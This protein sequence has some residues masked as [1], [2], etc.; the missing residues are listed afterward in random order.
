MKKIGILIFVITLLTIY[1][2]PM[3]AAAAQPTS[4]KEEVI[5]G[6]LNSDGSVNNIYV[7]NIF[8]GGTIDD[9]GNYSEVSNMTSTEPMNK[10]EDHITLNTTADKFYYQGTLNSK[11]LPWNIVIR[12]FLNGSELSA[13]ELAGKSGTLK[14]AIT[15]S[16][17]RNSNRTFYD[18]YALQIG[19]SLDNKL[20]SKIEAENATIAEA[21]GNKQ[22]SYTVLP[23]NGIEASVSAV[24]QDFEMEAITVN[25]IKLAMGIDVDTDEFTSQVTELS[26][27]IKG[28]D[29]GAEELLNGLGRLSNGMQS[30][31]EGMRPF[32]D[33]IGKLAAGTDQLNEGAARLEDGLSELVK[34]NTAILGGVAA[35]TQ[36][37]FDAVNTQ[38]GAMGLGLPALTPENYSSVLSG[39]PEL[40]KV[41]EQL[42][43]VV[44]FSQGLTGYMNAVEQIKDGASQLSVGIN[45][46]DSSA[47]V[48]AASANQL[49]LA[50]KELNT[51]IEKVRDG[52]SEYKEGTNK[53]RNGTSD[54]SS[55][56]DT[57][58]DEMLESI[59]GGKDPIISF[60]SDKNTNI[61]SVQFVLKTQAIQ[62]PELTAVE[63]EKPVKL[64]F[65]QKLLKLFGLYHEKTN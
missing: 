36:S 4:A 43:G 65:W 26:K 23:G 63:T 2:A 8:D 22:I 49:Y 51:G 54:I 19:V 40:S 29:T 3:T 55:E 50:G 10:R 59:S 5:Y 14:I 42:D 20:C 48:I 53:L 61:T 32:K 33:G 38:L 18:N 21:G 27:A 60:T 25:G 16:Q 62:Q 39:A 47:S 35:I 37:T 57:K 56:I 58:V 64:T 24:V 28:L 12:Y 31:V 44:Q 13:A 11:E 52:L 9:Y 46:F 6:I 7:V 15:V 34:Q 30:Y 1:T 45:K 17:N 41:K